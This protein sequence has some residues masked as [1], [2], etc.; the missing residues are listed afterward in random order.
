MKKLTLIAM[1]FISASML[2]CPQFSA[3]NAK[4][5]EEGQT[6]PVDQISIQ[7]NTFTLSAFGQVQTQTLPHVETN[8]DYTMRSE[9]D[10]NSVVTTETF[11]EH[12][13]V[14]VTTL[15]GSQIIT[16]GET[17]ILGCPT[18]DCDNGPLTFDGIVADSFSCIW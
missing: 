18:G 13:A 3:T 12:T 6:F 15:I 11:R 5:T 8:G 2:A 10:G 9:C 14:A 1:T 7:G 17:M 16:T 4:C